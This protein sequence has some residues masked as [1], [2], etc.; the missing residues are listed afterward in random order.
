VRVCGVGVYLRTNRCYSY[1]QMRGIKK[2]QGEDDAAEVST[3]QYFFFIRSA[4]F[5][6]PCDW[7]SENRIQARRRNPARSC[8]IIIHSRVHNYTWT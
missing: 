3:P 7:G 8:L 4:H 5:L 6:V 1:M 2:L